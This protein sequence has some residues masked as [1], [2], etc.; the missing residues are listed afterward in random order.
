MKDMELETGVQR[1]LDACTSGD[2]DLIAPV[3]HPGYAVGEP[4]AHLELDPVLRQ[5]GAQRRCPV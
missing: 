1:L 5:L 3:L 2:A 4:A